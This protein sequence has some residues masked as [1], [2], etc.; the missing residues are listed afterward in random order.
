MNLR[1][2]MNLGVRMKSGPRPIPMQPKLL[3]GNRGKDQSAPRPSRCATDNSIRHAAST[4]APTACHLRV[5]LLR[6]RC[7]RGLTWSHLARGIADYRPSG[8][9]L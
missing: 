2:R 8:S 9:D 6:P 4:S 7:L 5:K 3:R 1:V